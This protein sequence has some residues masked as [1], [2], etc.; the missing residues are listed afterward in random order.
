VKM[1][2]PRLVEYSK[3][4]DREYNKYSQWELSRL[5]KHY[6]L[7][8]DLSTR[9]L[10]RDILG[11]DPSFSRGW[12]AMNILHHLKLSTE[13]KGVFKGIEIPILISALKQNHQDFDDIIRLL[14]MKDPSFEVGEKLIAQGLQSESN[15]R[16]KL[17]THLK[18]PTNTDG[19]TDNGYYRR[20]QAALRALLFGEATE[21]QCAI[22]LKLFPVEIMVTAHIK[23]R[24]ECSESERLDP[25][26][27]MPV[28]RMGCDILYEKCYLIVDDLGK[29]TRL[30]DIPLPQALIVILNGLEGNKCPYFDDNTRAYFSD[31]R[32]NLRPDK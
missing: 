14:E 10:D 12:F 21:F 7:Y 11:E 22:C 6:L 3:A 18:L 26:V 9:G 24:S 27:V 15:F 2:I 30:P 25:S 8:G 29:V 32:Q 16:R 28:C 5:V 20:E 23:Q 4:R 1:D 19:T 17:R 31:K 13:F